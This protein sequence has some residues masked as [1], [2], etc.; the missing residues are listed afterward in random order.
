MSLQKRRPR[1]PLFS[2]RLKSVLEKDPFDCVSCDL[3]AEIIKCVFRPIVNTRF[4][5]RER[6]AIPSGLHEH[7]VRIATKLPHSSLNN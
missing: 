2:A 5:D 1:H 6:W 3:M 4:G 7:G